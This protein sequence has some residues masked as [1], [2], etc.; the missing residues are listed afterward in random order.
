M[1]TVIQSVIWA[2]EASTR[3]QI[4]FLRLVDVYGFDKFTAT[5]DEMS[6]AIK[7]GPALLAKTMSRLRSIG[8]V[9]SKRLY[10]VR[11]NG[12]KNVIGCEYTL[13]KP[14]LD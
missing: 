2:E 6:E 3:D 7:V 13:L 8:W 12:M 1:A 5:L 14:N 9:D 11:D 10:G 4:V